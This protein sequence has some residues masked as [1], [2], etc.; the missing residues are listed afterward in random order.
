MIYIP[1]FASRNDTFS[2]YVGL[3][4]CFVLWVRNLLGPISAAHISGFLYK[5][6]VLEQI[7]IRPMSGYAKSGRSCMECARVATKEA[8]FDIDNVTVL[9]WY[10]DKCVAKASLA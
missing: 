1:P 10:C 7:K 8:A 6:H 9:R 2:C 4:W 3:I 5:L